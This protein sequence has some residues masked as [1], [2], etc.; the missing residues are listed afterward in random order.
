MSD[1]ALLPVA[2]DFVPA[3]VLGSLQGAK[4][5]NE[6]SCMQAKNPQNPVGLGRKHLEASRVFQMFLNVSETDTKSI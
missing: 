6:K 2:I 4:F 1:M 5:L 3:I